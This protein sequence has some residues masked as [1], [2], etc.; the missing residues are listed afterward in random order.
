MATDQPWLEKDR[1]D[2]LCHLS[3]PRRLCQ[4]P[5][6]RHDAAVAHVPSDGEPITPYGMDHCSCR[7]LVYTKYDSVNDMTLDVGIPLPIQRHSDEL[8]HGCR[9][10]ATRPTPLVPPLTC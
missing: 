3:R 10:E 1:G 4:V 9:S 2:V 8:Q 5:G 7:K 6:Q